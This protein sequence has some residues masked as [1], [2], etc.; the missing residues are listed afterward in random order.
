MP[1][2]NTRNR[3][4]T[5]SNNPANSKPPIHTVRFGSVK[6]AIWQNETSNGHMYNVTV[7]R[8]YRDGEQ[9]KDSSSFGPDE[10]LTLAKA[11]DEA[12][13]WIFE[14]RARDREEE[15]AA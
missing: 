9:F 3:M 15:Q 1:N 12:H 4:N 14:Q 2:H 5:T 6:A 8:T 10:L 7:S 11:L 13:S